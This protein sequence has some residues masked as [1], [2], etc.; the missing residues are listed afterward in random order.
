M[1]EI[2]FRAW[3]EKAKAMFSVKNILLN[4]ITGV[5]NAIVKVLC[6]DSKKEETFLY[7]NIMQYTGLKDKNGKEIYEGDIVSASDSI[8]VYKIYVVEWLH[9]HCGFSLTEHGV[10]SGKIIGRY[11]VEVIGNI[12]ENQELL[13]GK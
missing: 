8:G 7:S 2:K 11:E 10:W 5:A 9:N 6:I 12:Y 13:N 3:D 4:S 1:R